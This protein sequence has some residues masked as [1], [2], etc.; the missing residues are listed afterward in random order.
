MLAVALFGCIAGEKDASQ[1]YVD[2]YIQ[3]SSSDWED[4]L[5]IESRFRHVGRLAHYHLLYHERDWCGAQKGP[6]ELWPI[7]T[8]YKLVVFSSKGR[9]GYFYLHSQARD[10]S[11]KDNEVHFFLDGFGKDSIVFREGSIPENTESRDIMFHKDRF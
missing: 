4:P 2:E 6:R 9:E 8:T 1:P 7:R 10:F 5:L 3:R 11:I